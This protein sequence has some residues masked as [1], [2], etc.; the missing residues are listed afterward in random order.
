MIR[1][2]M[3][4]EARV[5]NVVEYVGPTHVPEATFPDLRPD[6][7]SRHN[8]ALTSNYWVPAMNR[9]VI[10]IQIWVVEVAGAVIVVDPGVGNRKHRAPARMD[11]LNTLTLPWL[12]AAGASRERVTHVVMTHLHG[13]HIGWNTLLED[14]QWR[15]TFPHARYLAPLA[16]YRYFRA[17][18]DANPAD[19]MA[20]PLGDSLLPIEQAGRL[21]LFE[22]DTRCIADTLRVVPAHGHTPG[23]VTLELESGGQNGVF[24][25][26]ILHHPLQIL[27]PGLNTAFCI[28]GDQARAVRAA[29]L[30]RVAE[31]RTLVMPAH[32]PWPGCGYVRRRDGGYIFE[33]ESSIVNAA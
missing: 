8:R 29:F 18:Y 23:M 15:P 28:L 31:R 4:G 13:D 12:E 21:E 25:G 26:D 2:R 19:P 6:M 22:A 16:D 30:A 33:E 7:L 14:G 5:T 11:M 17:L 1:T 9:L 20:G 27:E 10:A 32:F 3:I 24:S